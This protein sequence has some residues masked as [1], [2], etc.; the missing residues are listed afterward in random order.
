MHK[1]N[2]FLGALTNVCQSDKFILP[3]LSWQAGQDC[4]AVNSEEQIK[5]VQFLDYLTILSV[6]FIVPCAFHM[7]QF[8]RVFF[9][10]GN[11]C[12]SIFWEGSHG[13]K[14]NLNQLHVAQE[15]YR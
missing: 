5:V 7:I 3:S 14:Y 15:A 12:Y 1:K 6:I 9:Y 10:A 8:S 2:F 11:L 4:I 13:R